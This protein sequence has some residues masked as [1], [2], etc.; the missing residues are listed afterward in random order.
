LEARAL[1]ARFSAGLPN[2]S[3]GLWPSLNFDFDRWRSD[4]RRAYI[5]MHAKRRAQDEERQERMSRAIVQLAAVEGFSQLE[6]LGPPQGVDLKTRYEELAL[7]LVP[8]ARLE[9]D[10]SLIIQPCCDTCGMSLSSPQERQDIDGFLFELES[11]LRSY[12]RRLSSVAVRETLDN[13][14]SD[15]LATLIKLREAADLS[16]LSNHLGGDVIDFLQEFL[17]ASNSQG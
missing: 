17:A 8:C 10:M 4:Y 7:G 12:N 1:R 3:D 15:R 6:E 16:A 2:D 11:V 5:A 13:R 9:Y 14:Q